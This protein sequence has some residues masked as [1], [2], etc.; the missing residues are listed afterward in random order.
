MEGKRYIVREPSVVEQLKLIRQRRFKM[1]GGRPTVFL[2]ERDPPYRLAE[3]RKKDNHEYTLLRN[4]MLG[5][6][7][8]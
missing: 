4:N 1:E 7:D 3:L 5:D 8:L 2:K 6:Y